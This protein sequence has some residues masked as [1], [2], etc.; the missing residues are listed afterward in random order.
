MDLKN[1]GVWISGRI[2]DEDSAGRAAA[3][4]EEL[5]FGAVW[6]GGSPRLPS[7]RPMLS[8]GQSIPIATGIVNIWQ[9][10]PDQLAAEFAELEDEFPGRLLLGIGIGHPEATSEYRKPLTKTSEFLDGLDA[11]ERPVP[12]DRRCLAA[13]GPKMLDL[14][15]A[16]SLGTHPYFTPVAHTRFARERLGSGPLIAPEL[17]CVVGEDPGR[18]R[19]RAYGANYLRMSNYTNNLLRFGYEQSDIEN[20]G[21]DRLID[22]VVPQGSP[23]HIAEMARAHLDAGAD[24][25]CV[26]QVGASE[27]PEREWRALAGALLA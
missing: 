16:R 6:V 1:I 7:L 3:L 9:Y 22:E 14:S 12:A 19:A 20:G 4:A 15:A 13:L 17:A 8:A 26:Q 11:A 2:L 24:H 18:E 27:L 23:Q 25:V 5:G 10:D 21:S